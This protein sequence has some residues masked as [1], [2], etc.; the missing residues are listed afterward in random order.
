MYVRIRIYQLVDKE[1]LPIFVE[2][3]KAT[4][5]HQKGRLVGGLHLT[6]TK[7]MQTMLSYCNVG[8]TIITKVQYR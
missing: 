6:E 8:N 4:Q 3:M 1:Y 5:Y 2:R 7:T